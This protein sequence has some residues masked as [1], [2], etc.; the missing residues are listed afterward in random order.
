M[1][2]KFGK[3][4]ALW[5][6]MVIWL[7]VCGRVENEEWVRIMRE[8]DKGWDTTKESPFYREFCDI[9]IQWGEHKAG[10]GNLILTDYARQE[11]ERYNAKRKNSI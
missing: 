4:P 3:L 5:R 2:P 6:E 8:R 9:Y 10:K 7:L 11:L 1:K